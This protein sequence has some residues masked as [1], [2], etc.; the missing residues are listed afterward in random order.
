ML[1]NKK[2]IKD[3]NFKNQF[4]NNMFND[5]GNNNNQGNAQKTNLTNFIK[6]SR[7][8]QVALI[9]VSLKLL[10]LIFFLFFKKA[11]Y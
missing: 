9:T 4:N 1:K 10:S 7:S 11:K 5:N 3:N 6:K 8:P 2:N